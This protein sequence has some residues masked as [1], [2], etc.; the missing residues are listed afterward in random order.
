MPLIWLAVLMKYLDNMVIIIIL[1]VLVLLL[2]YIS[3]NLYR[4]NVLLEQELEKAVQLEERIYT[5]VQD[6]FVENSQ[7]WI[8][9]KRV[10][11]LG[12]FEADD[13]VGF[14][15]KLIMKT[16]GTLKETLADI[17]KDQKEQD[18]D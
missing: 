5:L 15:F 13:E 18:G 9:I 11:K 2:S 14:V 10:D 1:S 17:L 12:S 4:K 16:V 7:A 3:I 6:L 8:R